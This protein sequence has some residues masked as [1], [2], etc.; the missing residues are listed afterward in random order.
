MATKK[1]GL[2][3]YSADG[4]FS[5]SDWEYGRNQMSLISGNIATELRLELLR[6]F[7]FE[8]L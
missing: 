3:V 7:L 8:Y 5:E 1:R 6:A 2:V 4:L